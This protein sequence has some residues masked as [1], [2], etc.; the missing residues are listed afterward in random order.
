M[1]GGKVSET[2]IEKLKWKAM[3]D[4]GGFIVPMFRNSIEQVIELDEY[5]ALKKADYFRISIGEYN[6]AVQPLWVENERETPVAELKSNIREKNDIETVYSHFKNIDLSN[7][8]YQDT[9]FMYTRFE[10]VNF[11]NSVMDYCNFQGSKFWG[12]NLQYEIYAFV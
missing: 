9:N 5:K 4:Y 2:Y 7:D 1:Y 11:E 8:D 6:A 12:C 10:N 3:E